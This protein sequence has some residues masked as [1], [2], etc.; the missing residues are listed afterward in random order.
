MLSV[1]GE[2]NRAPL[3]VRHGLPACGIVYGIREWRGG[4]PRLRNMAAHGILTVVIWEGNEEAVLPLASLGAFIPHSAHES[5]LSLLPFY[6]GHDAHLPALDIQRPG[7]L[8][9]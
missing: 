5:G 1:V 6:P 4:F 3:P 8:K 9:G 2:A 7:L